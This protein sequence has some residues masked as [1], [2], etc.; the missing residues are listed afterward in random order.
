MAIRT[1]CVRCVMQVST[2][3][4]NTVWY[5]PRCLQAGWKVNNI[6]AESTNVF[7]S[8]TALNK[9]LTSRFLHL[10]NSERHLHRLN[11]EENLA[12]YLLGQVFTSVLK[13]NNIVSTAIEII[14]EESAIGSAEWIYGPIQ[15]SLTLQIMPERPGRW[16]RW[17]PMKGGR[18]RKAD[19]TTSLGRLHHFLTPS[20]EVRTLGYSSTEVSPGSLHSVCTPFWYAVVYECHVIVKMRDGIYLGFRRHWLLNQTLPVSN[21]P[22]SPY[23]WSLESILPEVLVWYWNVLIQKVSVLRNRSKYIQ[24]MILEE[25]VLLLWEVPM[26]CSATRPHH[27]C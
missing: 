7:Q 22:D 13:I 15:R 8:K 25:K 6:H 16:P 14:K 17:P 1:H 11:R 3:K 18:C 12:P 20:S 9:S 10:E 24:K 19:D 23:Q 27:G 21:G 4:Y 2:P 5:D 26:P